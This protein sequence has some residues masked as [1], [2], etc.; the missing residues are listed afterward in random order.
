MPAVSECLAV[1]NELEPLP[2]AGNLWNRSVEEHK[3]EILGV[4]LAE[5]IDPP[6]DSPNPSHRVRLVERGNRSRKK[7]P[8][9]FLS[10]R[11]KDVVLAGEIAVNRS[12]AVFDPLGYFPDRYVVITLGDEQVPGCI[13][14]RPRNRLPLPFLTFFDPQIPSKKP[15]N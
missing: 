1:A 11:E 8:E 14:N 5:L 10:Q 15:F 6:H 12:W 2:V 7:Q 4:S 13:Q 3:G 9:T